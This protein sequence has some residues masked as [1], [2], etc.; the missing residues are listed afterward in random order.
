[1]RDGGRCWLVNPTTTPKSKMKVAVLGSGSKGNSALVKCGDTLILIDAGLSA[2]QLT[3]RLNILGVSPNDLGGILVTHEHGDH[4]KGLSV[5][6]KKL[7]IPVFAN[8]FTRE[9]IEYKIKSNIRWKI[10]RTGQDFQLGDITVQSFKVQHDSSE[11]VGFVLRGNGIQLGMISDVGKVTAKMRKSLRGC[12][13]LYIEANY[14]ETLLAQDAK[15]PITI[16]RRISS[17]HGHLSNTQTAEFLG[18]IACHKLKNI[19]LCHLSSDCNSPEIAIR[20]VSETLS[21]VGYSDIKIHCAPQHHPTKWL[22]CGDD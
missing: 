18:E 4:I 8:L 6:L 9:A 12:H 17:D 1:M 14:D 10:F 22:S 5:F 7:N 15:R 2:K 16:K 13:A 3:L 20:T 19:T 11:P 21:R